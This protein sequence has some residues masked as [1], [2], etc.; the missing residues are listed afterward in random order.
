MT[1]QRAY[2]LLCGFYTLLVG[3]GIIALL[4]GAGSLVN[5]A[6]VAV[7][8]VAVVGLW[9]HTLGRGYLNPR[10]W[11]PLAVLLVAGIVI[12]VLAIFGLSPSGVGLTWLLTGTIFSVLPALL[13]YRYGERDQEVW[14]T[15][16]ER[17]DGR[18][19]GELLASRDRLVVEK[20]EADRKAS[21]TLTKAGNE[22]R[23]SVVRRYP[24]RQER[25]EERFSC[26]ATLAFFIEKFTCIS[27]GDI[28]QAH[29]DDGA[30]AT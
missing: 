17:E 18:V 15:P 23:A 19:L 29:R 14:A 16:E 13:L 7:G 3:I 28:V 11:R 4:L 30:A 10:Q 21:L 22:Y 25:F 26:P 20:Q 6:Q 9:G 1:L 27:V 12:Q 24:D 5:L 2:L 8:A